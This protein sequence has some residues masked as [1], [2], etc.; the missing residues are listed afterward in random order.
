MSV[1]L[2]RH[3]PRFDLPPQLRVKFPPRKSSLDDVKFPRRQL[4]FSMRCI[5]LQVVETPIGDFVTLERLLAEFY[6]KRL[7]CRPL[8]QVLRELEEAT[9]LPNPSTLN[10]AEGLL[11][12]SAE[13][14][15]FRLQ[16]TL[17]EPICPPA[18]SATA[19]VG[20]GWA[21]GPTAAAAHANSLRFRLSESREFLD[22]GDWHEAPFPSLGRLLSRELQRL[23]KGGSPLT[24][25]TPAG[26][27]AVREQAIVVPGFPAPAPFAT[28][29]PGKPP[30]E[31]RA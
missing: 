3:A 25:L 19:Y 15:G 6:E 1:E 27:Q 10:W 8:L 30:D 4:S 22:Q 31:T 29:S 21:P 28:E 12:P 16:G 18:D 26:R 24:L 11:L 23:V 7:I 5:V 17:V 2:F 13:A 9:N 20:I 14:E